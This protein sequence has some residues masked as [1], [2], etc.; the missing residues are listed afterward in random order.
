MLAKMPTWP[1]VTAML[2]VRQN[3]GSAAILRWGLLSHLLAPWVI[4]KVFGVKVIGQR[5]NFLNLK[6][7][8]SVSLG[9]V[10]ALTLCPSLKLHKDLK[11]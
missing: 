10:L 9:W 2:F 11:S 8:E 6:V 5:G 1:L 7:A 4:F 3:I